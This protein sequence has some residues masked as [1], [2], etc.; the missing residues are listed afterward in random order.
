[1]PWLTGYT[2]TP[3]VYLANELLLELGNSL[4]FQM[5]ATPKELWISANFSYK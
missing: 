5:P 2:S 3:G 1:M 4:H